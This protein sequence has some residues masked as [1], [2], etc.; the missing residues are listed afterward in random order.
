MYTIQSDEPMAQRA[1]HTLSR[2]NRVSGLARTAAFTAALSIAAM[3][4]GAGQVSAQNYANGIG[5][6]AGGVWFS[7]FNAGSAQVGSE[8]PVDIGLDPGWIVGLQYDRWIGDGRFGARLNGA[9]TSRPI[10]LPGPSR[11]I[12][13]WMLDGDLLVRLL[14]PDVD[15][16]F[17]MFISL[18][19]GVVRYKLGNGELLA[20]P[21]ANAAHDGNDGAQFAANAGLGFDFL[22]AWD[23]DGSPVGIRFE[24]VD[25]VAIKSPFDPI[26]GDDFSPVHNVRFV[27]GAYTGF[28]LLRR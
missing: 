25:H 24:V 17:N 3:I 16:L 1:G 14:P 4:G 2:R 10:D 21:A 12:A 7:E 26:A 6:N 22:T 20:L 13:V 23:W 11:D 5:Y 28:G 27:I 9:L 8:A 15:R 18:G 19:A